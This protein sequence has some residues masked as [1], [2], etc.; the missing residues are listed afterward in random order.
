MARIRRPALIL[1]ALAISAL[2]FSGC[3]ANGGGW[4]NSAVGA[5]KA[6]FGFTWQGDPYGGTATLAKGSWS[7]GYVKFRIAN[8][9]ITF[10][11]PSSG[12][13]YGSGQYVSTNTRQYSGSGNIYITICD[14][15]EPGPTAGDYVS[16]CLD[17]GPYDGYYNSD[18]LRGGNLQVKSQGD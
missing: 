2:V 3:L 15:G 7:D 11:D 13:V 6:T 8:G 18:T 5:K 14:N 16:V 17:G 1:G 10:G 4:I 12:C 9:G